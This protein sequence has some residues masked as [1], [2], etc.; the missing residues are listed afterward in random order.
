MSVVWFEGLVCYEWEAN[1][2][3]HRGLAPGAVS[4]AGHL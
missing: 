4:V 1:Q 2:R 3:L